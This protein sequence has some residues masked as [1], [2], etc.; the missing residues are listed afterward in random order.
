VSPSGPPLETA[1][2]L[3]IVMGAPFRLLKLGK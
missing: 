2:A 3:L 1:G